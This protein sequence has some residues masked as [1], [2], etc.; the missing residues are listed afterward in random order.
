MRSI[1]VYLPWFA[2]IIFI[3]VQNIYYD[4]SWLNLENE[5]I[6]IV[7]PEDIV[8]EEFHG[9]FTKEI[10]EMFLDKIPFISERFIYLNDNYY[11]H[12]FIHPRFFFNE[13][14]FPKY[15]FDFGTKEKP[16]IIQYEER[17]FYKTYDII[18]EYF[19]SNYV[20][21]VQD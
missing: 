15:N 9:K 1:E 8:P 16:K 6:K 12:N 11:F 3:I 2:G 21:I 17:A 10:I 13:E 18:K 14:F 4:L 7:N 19:G 5:H 20:I